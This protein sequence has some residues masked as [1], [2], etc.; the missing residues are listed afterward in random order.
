MY[1]KRYKG[2]EQAKVKSANQRS[3]KQLDTQTKTL[4]KDKA[5]QL[6]KAKHRNFYNRQKPSSTIF[7]ISQG[8]TATIKVV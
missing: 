4:A 1:K 7:F 6:E 5:M 2:K 3:R 8:K